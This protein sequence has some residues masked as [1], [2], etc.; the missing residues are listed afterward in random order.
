MFKLKQKIKNKAQYEAAAPAIKDSLAHVKT[1]DDRIALR[2]NNQR[3]IADRIDNKV[4][5]AGLVVDSLI[6]VTGNISKYVEVQMNSVQK[7][8]DEI[9]S[10][11]ALAEEVFANTENARQISEQTMSVARKGSSAVDDSIEAMNVIEAS[12]LESKDVINMLSKKAAHINEMLDVIKDIADNT[13]LLSLNASIEAARAGEA[14]RGFAVVAQEVKKL[15][16]RSVDSIKYINTTINE[17]NE[18]V[19][20]ALDSMDK[21]IDKVKE[22]TDISKNTMEV[23]NTIIKAVD[24]NSSVSDEINTAITKQTANLEVVV[25]S[26]HEM[27]RTFEKLITTVE[28]AVLYTQFTKTSLESL[29]NTASD[30]KNSTV[31]LVDGMAGSDTFDTTVTTCL[32]SP[33]QTYDPQMS[34]EYVGSHIMSNVNSGLLTISA[35][36]HVS[37]GI[38]K[39]WYLEEDGLT[40]VFLLRKGAKFHNGREITAEDV[41]Y[42]FERLLSPGLNSPNSWALMCLDGAEEYNSGKE[43][44]VRGMKVRDK[45]RISLRLAAPH[46]GF[47]LNLG[48]FCASILPQED[49]GKGVISGCGPYRLTDIQPSGITLEAFRDFYNGE[50]YV[51]KITVKYKDINVAEDL[52]NGSYDFIIADKKNIINTIKDKQDIIVKTRSIIGTYYVGFNLFSSSPYVQNKEVRKALNMA[53]N[54]KIIIDELLG[55]LAIEAKGPFPPSMIDNT[56]DAGYKYDPKQAREILQRIITGKAVQKL[57][58]LAREEND[59]S[60]YNPLT[61]YIIK[62]LKEMGIECEFVR[63]KAS[64]YLN[65]ECIRRCD[66]YVSRWIGDTGDPDNFLQPLF[67]SDSKT[68]YSSYKNEEVTMEMNKAKEIINPEKRTEMYRKIQ[69]TIV[70]EAPW[71]FL[72]HPQTGIAY[73][74]NIAG[75]RLSQLGLLKYEDIILENI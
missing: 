63:V 72:Y 61:E 31:K 36:G 41:R 28:Q 30:L 26:T 66:I 8:V 53:V 37:P 51:K 20:K 22:G 11:S 75:I 43:K 23:F 44:A 65:P 49:I 50:S 67:S 45:Y 39:T 4:G 52:I 55:G 56:N 1:S 64:E 73:R 35:S 25:N 57:K 7:V 6:D 13:N 71:I 40:W 10:Y 59:T 68:N 48:Q 5:E 54:K 15:A 34:F 42:S 24:N 74:N 58:V 69:Q 14:G 47:L 3:H 60:I 32:P 16:Q 62:D 19:V 38:A 29:Q 9:S 2:K 33:L 21:T 27:S 12:V 46:S 70:D 17:I 18:S